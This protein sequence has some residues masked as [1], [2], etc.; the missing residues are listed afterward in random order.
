M[1]KTKEVSEYG[2]AEDQEIQ[3]MCILVL[4]YNDVDVLWSSCV[5]DRLGYT[6]S[7]IYREF[8]ITM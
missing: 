6:C 5:K 2:V 7:V 4:Q 1:K 3:Y 8:E